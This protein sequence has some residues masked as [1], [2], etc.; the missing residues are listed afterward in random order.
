MKWFSGIALGCFLVL[1]MTALS[2][3]CA[4]TQPYL[5][6]ASWDGKILKYDLRTGS[7]LSV[8]ASNH[9]E[10]LYY[11]HGMAFDQNG[12]LYVCNLY[13]NKILQYNQQGSVEVFAQNTVT[14]P[15]GLCVTAD[16]LF[17]S[18]LKNNSIAEFD[19]VTKQYLGDIVGSNQKDL[20]SPRNLRIGP[21]GNLWVSS[22][23]TNSILCYDATN[24]IL[25]RTII[26]GADNGLEDIIFAPDGYLYGSC[27]WTNK[28]VKIDWQQ[29][30]Y[31][32]DFATAAQGVSRPRGLALSPDGAL[33]YVADETK[34]KIQAFNLENG[35]MQGV[36]DPTNKGG[37]NRVTFITVYP[38]L[39]V[40]ECLG[41]VVLGAGIMSFVSFK[42]KGRR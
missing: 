23:G 32:S 16:K 2:P 1:F 27:W 21:D 5:L 11:P 33:L 41:L 25:K 4:S 14:Q 6:A 8:F 20:I 39:T 36:F 15:M 30:V 22:V 40:P 29:G 26:L 38:S 34:N 31:V 10:Q 42:L 9:D 35:Q 7:F 18:S 3:I 17:V 13:M 24:G 37:L 19:L 12:N 28:V